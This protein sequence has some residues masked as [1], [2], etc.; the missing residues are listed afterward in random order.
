MD[1]KTEGIVND[2][3]TKMTEKELKKNKIFLFDFANIKKIYANY[4]CQ[5]KITLVV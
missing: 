3:S 2:N 5:G 4:I 1:P